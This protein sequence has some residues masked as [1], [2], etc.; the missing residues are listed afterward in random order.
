MRLIPIRAA[1]RTLV[2]LMS[3]SAVHIALGA[4]FTTPQPA[5]A[6]QAAT[7]V[8]TVQAAS[9]VTPAGQG[10]AGDDSPSAPDA[11]APT[12]GFVCIGFGC[13]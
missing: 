2:R 7:F 10:D 9:V 6:P 13:G 8:A 11:Q 5:L 3:A 12:P 4:T 1:G